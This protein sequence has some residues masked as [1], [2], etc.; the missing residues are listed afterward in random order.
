MKTVGPGMKE[1]HNLVGTMGATAAAGCVASLNAQQMRWLLD[2]PTQRAGAGIGAWRQ[3]TEHIEKAFLFGAMGLARST[4]LVVH[5]A[6][7]ANDVFCLG[8]TISGVLQ[9]E[10]DRQ[11]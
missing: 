10:A 3:D 11:G 4:P 1:T 7:L 2:W 6:G 8:P 5:R 9:P